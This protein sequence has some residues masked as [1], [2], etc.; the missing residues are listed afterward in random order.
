MNEDEFRTKLEEVLDS[1]VEEIKMKGSL[2]WYSIRGLR[3]LSF[4]KRETKDLNLESIKDFQDVFK[5]GIENV[6]H[7]HHQFQIPFNDD[8]LLAS[9]YGIM[10]TIFEMNMQFKK[11][12]KDSENIKYIS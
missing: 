7:L 6:I 5:A 9:L 2:A 4:V 3:V 8:T 10:D 1:K 12:M 11:Y